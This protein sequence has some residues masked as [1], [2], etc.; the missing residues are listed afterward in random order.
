VIDI[1]LPDLD[2]GTEADIIADN[3]RALSM[4]Y[5]SAMLE[6]LKYFAVMDKV[7]DQFMSGALPVKRG[8]AGDPLYQYHRNAQNRINEYERRGLY[9]RSFGVAQGS[10]IVPVEGA[11]LLGPLPGEFASTTIFTAGIGAPSKVVE[12][13]KSLIQFLGGPVARPLLK[14]KGFQSE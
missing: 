7:V 14:A 4:I 6:E 3:V 1:D 2:A 12:E 11:E 9:A 5:F 8:S 10:E 13:A